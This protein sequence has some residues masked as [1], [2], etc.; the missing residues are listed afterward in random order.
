[1]INPTN[2]NDFFLLLDL[3]GTLVDTDRIHA[4]C[5][6]Q[7]GA[8]IEN[9]AHKL[10]RGELQVSLEIKQRKAKLVEEMCKRE[11]VQWMPG[12]EELLTF[13][14]TYSVNYCIVTNTPRQPVLA[15]CSQLPLLHN[16]YQQGRLICREEY[17][18]PKPHCDGY[19]LAIQR[20]YK[21]EK[22]ILGFENTYIGWLA[23]ESLGLSIQTNYFV[24]ASGKEEEEDVRKRGG[25]CIPSLKIIT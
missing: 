18:K 22:H 1:M 11:G 14:S 23:L 7:A 15:M 4:E 6:K 17:E 25:V 8:P 3:D 20:W 19:Q 24:L 16:A 12:A 9:L 5:Y 13:C 2:G 21:N 10:R